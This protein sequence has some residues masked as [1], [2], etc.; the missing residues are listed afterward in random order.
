MSKF[1]AVRQT[2]LFKVFEDIK[3]AN[4]GN[5]FEIAMEQVDLYVDIYDHAEECDYIKAFKKYDM[6]VELVI[7]LGNE[8]K[9]G[10][11]FLFDEQLVKTN[12]TLKPIKSFIYNQWRFK[13]LDI[14]TKRLNHP[15]K[16]I[17]HYYEELVR[18]F[19]PYRHDDKQI[20]KN[21]LGI[22]R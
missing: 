3:K 2:P 11:N 9:R 10:Q 8:N 17:K 4:Q 16:E 18:E 21:K 6:F 20:M 7:H 13:K 14:N 12:E 15:T 22:K 1:K 5:L 19:T